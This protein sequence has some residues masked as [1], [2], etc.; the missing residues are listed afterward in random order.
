[1]ATLSIW[2]ASCGLR[3]QTARNDAP[4]YCLIRECYRDRWPPLRAG[5]ERRDRVRRRWQR[6]PRQ[7]LWTG[8][9][10]HSPSRPQRRQLRLGCKPA[11]DRGAVRVKHRG[12]PHPGLVAPLGAPVRGAWLPGLGRLAERLGE[13]GRLGRRRCGGLAV[14][15]MGTLASPAIEARAEQIL[16][17]ADLGQ[18][19]DGIERAIERLARR[20]LIALPTLGCASAR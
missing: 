4:S 20:C 2:R 3:C 12:H 1:M 9:A 5:G 13:G 19:S 10:F 18:E 14:G 8:R 11:F 6:T 7:G 16:R 17:R 15:V